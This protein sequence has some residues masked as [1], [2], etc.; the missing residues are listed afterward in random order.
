MIYDDWYDDE[1]YENDW[2]EEDDGYYYDD[3]DY[4]DDEPFYEDD[5]DDCGWD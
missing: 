4:Y 1:L 3:G 5:W 2:N